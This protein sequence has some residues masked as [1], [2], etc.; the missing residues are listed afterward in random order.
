[1]MLGAASQHSHPTTHCG[2]FSRSWGKGGVKGFAVYLFAEC[3]LV[4]C[5]L[6]GQC[7]CKRMSLLLLCSSSCI[8]AVSAFSAV[9]KKQ[10]VLGMLQVLLLVPAALRQEQPSGQGLGV[11]HDACP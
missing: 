6:G 7:C 1:M 2:V 5:C 8:K 4:C 3:C 11:V 9:S 10:G